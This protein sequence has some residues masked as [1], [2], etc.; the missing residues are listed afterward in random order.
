MLNVVAQEYQRL[1]KQPLPVIVVKRTTPDALARRWANCATLQ[2]ALDALKTNGVI[3]QDATIAGFLRL[4]PI[5]ASEFKDAMNFGRE[6]DVHAKRIG[7]R[8]RGLIRDS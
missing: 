5:E 6:T 3:P 1:G 7:G 2:P 8:I 4:F